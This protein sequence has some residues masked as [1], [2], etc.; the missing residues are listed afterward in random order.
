[1]FVKEVT[2]TDYNGNQRTETLYFNLTKSEMTQM[3]LAQEGG[4]DTYIKRIMET[5]NGQEIIDMFDLILSKSYGQKSLDGRRFIKSPEL[6]QEFKETEAYN[7]FFFELITDSEK[8]ADFVNGVVSS[9][10]EDK[11]FKKAMEEMNIDF[12]SELKE[13]ASGVNK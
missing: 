13:I 3:N 8:A 1:M 10:T 5:Q 2:Y 9:I 11:A 7:E 4:L 6:Y 12:Q